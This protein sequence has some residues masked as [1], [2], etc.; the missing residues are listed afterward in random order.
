MIL[1]R[2][3]APVNH[4]LELGDWWFVAV[5]ST[6]GAGIQGDFELLV[7]L[8]EYIFTVKTLDPTLV[9]RDNG[10][11]LYRRHCLKKLDFLESENLRYV[12]RTTMT[13]ANCSLSRGSAFREHF[14]QYG[15]CHWWWSR[16]IVVICFFFLS[17]FF[18]LCLRVSLL[19]YF[20]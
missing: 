20:D 5:A 11:L 8:L 3:D 17:S 12:D 7:V 9:V 2:C 4:T 16:S 19:R 13:L 1:L 14:L 15:R 18:I 10:D 6:S